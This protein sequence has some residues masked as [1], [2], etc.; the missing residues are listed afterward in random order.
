MRY[1]EIVIGDVVSPPRYFN[2]YELWLE[3]HTGDC[4]VE[5]LEPKGALD[6]INE[7]AAA[8]DLLGPEAAESMKYG[9]PWPCY[10]HSVAAPL[11]NL[12]VF[13]YNFKGVKRRVIL[14]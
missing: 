10:D 8:L 5:I 13:Y 2:K 14:K 1:S 3:F 12:T 7:W 11:V 4:E 9:F 6:R